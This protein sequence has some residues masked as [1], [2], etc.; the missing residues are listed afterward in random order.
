MGSESGSTGSCL[1]VSAAACLPTCSSWSAEKRSTPLLG[2]TRACDNGGATILATTAIARNRLGGQRETGILTILFQ[3]H[4]HQRAFRLFDEGHVAIRI[5]IN[6]DVIAQLH[7][8][9]GDQVGQG[10]YQ[11][12]L[13]GPLQVT[14]AVLGIGAFVQQE[15]LD[16]RGATEDKLAVTGG[17][18]NALLHH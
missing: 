12:A 2:W 6:A 4:R 17:L 16:P 8:A 7:L 18:Q 10:K 15:A 14:G 5:H 1:L 11:I 13:N 9:G 3:Q